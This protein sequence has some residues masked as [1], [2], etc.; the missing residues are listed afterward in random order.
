MKAKKKKKNV[1][2][3]YRYQLLRHSSF[4]LFEG[5]PFSALKKDS[6]FKSLTSSAYWSYMH[7][8]ITFDNF[9]HFKDNIGYVFKKHEIFIATEKMQNQ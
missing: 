5:Q 3:K 7:M 9:F 4:D 6:P 2:Y 1:A 8:H